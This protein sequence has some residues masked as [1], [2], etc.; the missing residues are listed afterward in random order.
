VNVFFIVLH[1]WTSFGLMLDICAGWTDIY[2]MTLERKEELGCYASPSPFT[3]LLPNAYV[4]FT[5]KSQKTTNRFAVGYRIAVGDTQ[6]RALL[7]I[8]GG[9][10]PQGLFP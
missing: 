4:P 5:G 9:V 6:C 7:D 2:V 1:F 3:E 10:G 8:A